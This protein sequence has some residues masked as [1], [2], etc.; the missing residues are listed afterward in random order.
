MKQQYPNNW[1]VR[2][3]QF[4]MKYRWLVLLVSFATAI[5]M[6][7]GGRFLAFSNDYRNFFGE[8]NP[9]LIAFEELENS[10]TK[11]DNLMFIVSSKDGSIFS[12]K[13]LAAVQDITKEAW[14][15]PYSTRV[16]SITNFQ[17]TKAVGDDLFV[18]D[19]VKGDPTTLTSEQLREL[20]QI[21]LKEP[22]LK[23]LLITEK[24]NVTGVNVS[25]QLPG[26][27]PQEVN[28][29][30]NF[31]RNLRDKINAQY[32]DLDVK[33]SGIIPLNNA[34]AEIGQKD[35]AT[36]TPFMYL[37][38]IIVMFLLLKTWAGTLAALGVIILSTMAAMGFAGYAGI[39]LTPPSA[40]APTI[41]LTL[42]I[43]DSVHILMT[44]M[45]LIKKGWSMNEAIIESMR[46][47]FAAVFLTSITTV[48][49]FL[50]LN[51]S[52]APPFHDLGNITAIGVIMAF[53]Y[54]VTFLP[55]VTSLLPIKAK[56]QEQ[57]NTFFENLAEIVI[58]NNKKFL[59]GT[60][61][62]FV[63]LTAS[64]SR[65]DFN[66]QFIRWFD[67]RVPF[68]S[69]AHY[70]MDN[71]TGI[72]SFQYSIDSGEEEGVSR[73]DY[74][75]KVDEF[76][77]W[78]RQQPEA[79]HVASYT[80]IMKRLNKTMHG[81]DEAWYRLPDDNDLAAQYLLLYEMSLPYGLD[82][83]NQIN[84]DKSSVKM[85]VT[86]QE[87]NSTQGREVSAR[88]DQWLVDNAPPAMQAKASGPS[89]MF[90][91]MSQ[92]NVDSMIKGTAIALALITL[93]MMI[94]LRSFTYGLISL[95]P[96]ML[97]AL[98]AF[99]F[100]ALTYQQVGMAIAVVASATLGIIVDDSVHFLTKFLRAK[101]EH[102]Y[103]T[104][105]AIRYA[106]STVGLALVTTSIILIIGFGILT[107]ST[108]L[109][110]WSLG[111]LSVI[112]ITIALLIDF[113]FLPAV[114]LL[115]DKKTKTT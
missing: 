110:N 38:M 6:G 77:D 50:C 92:R 71:L 14:Q 70:M 79:V 16:D 9:Q 3:T 12:Q 103:S 51:F 96:N 37:I 26:K 76:A 86:L 28:E 54:S 4:I 5:G 93:L 60:T 61:I 24:L 49:G 90:S 43:A 42:A 69:T 23:D 75:N 46:V 109:L 63:I 66:D 18:D 81:D 34:F 104:E 41:I 108:F 2:Y 20:E 17:H 102:N 56:V 53:L 11:S 80:D 83:N 73:P 107:Y 89:V 84:I 10:Y 32:P 115:F 44:M 74:M 88:G 36:L 112:T 106:F 55:A 113:F 62:L 94:T 68:R 114:L 78:W 87:L 25:I 105:D 65:I 59:V 7:S 85:V 52:D 100:W 101:R 21:V 1:I 45:T 82:L 8:D 72:Y 39:F 97:P 111:M 19:L 48:V 58:R 31:A 64:I 15:V 27:S 22:I 40:T 57:K 95:L 47:N 29:T 35:A 30:T 13:N 91:H 67:H 98:M 99:G 33:I